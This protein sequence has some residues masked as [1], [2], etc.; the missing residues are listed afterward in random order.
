MSKLS[1]SNSSGD[2]RGFKV[3]ENGPTGNFPGSLIDVEDA[4]GVEVPKYGEIGV[5]E[6]KDVTR[7]LFAYNANGKTYLVQSWEMTQSASERSA[8]YKLLNQMKGEPPKFDGNYD[9]V[10]EIGQTVQI[11]VGSKVSKK[12]TPYNYISSVAPLM[13]ELAHKAPK[14]SEVEVPG[15][16]RVPLD[17]DSDSPFSMEAA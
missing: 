11:T 15:G 16:R 2:V 14:L 10:D 7:F 4:F 1:K 6:N 8:L 17:D 9:Y 5:Y 3:E 13:E 12:G